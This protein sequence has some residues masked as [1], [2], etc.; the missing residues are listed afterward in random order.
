MG[1]MVCLEGASADEGKSTFAKYM[2]DATFA[3]PTPQVLQKIIT[4]LDDLY[5]HDIAD[6]YMRGDLYE[7]MLGK[8]LTIVSVRIRA[9]LFLKWILLQMVTI[10]QSTSIKKWSMRL[11]SI[12]RRVRL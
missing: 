9:S 10:Y 7:Y 6:I 1:E 2:E 4:G 11:S 12:H 3:I 8:L 5:E